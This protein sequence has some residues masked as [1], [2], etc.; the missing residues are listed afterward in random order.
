[1]TS[2]EAGLSTITS[3]WDN[4]SQQVYIN[5]WYQLE[6]MLSLKQMGDIP[7]MYLTCFKYLHY[8][9]LNHEVDAVIFDWLNFKWSQSF[10]PYF[11]DFSLQF[12]QKPS[13]ENLDQNLLSGLLS[14]A[15]A[16]KAFGWWQIVW[17]ILL[18][19]LHVYLQ[20]YNSSHS[21]IQHLLHKQY[22]FLQSI[23]SFALC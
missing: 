20:D 7:N 3:C 12:V 8:F 2:Q 17:L 5:L 15:P 6:C 18:M 1:M 22:D 21:D 10:W 13:Q 19:T 9:L 16:Q 23:P 14:I 4:M 11:S